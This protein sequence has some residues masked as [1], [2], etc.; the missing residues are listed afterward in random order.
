MNIYIMNTSTLSADPS[1]KEYS[2]STHG[3]HPALSTWNNWTERAV[4]PAWAL[5]LSCQSSYCVLS[6]TLSQPSSLSYRL[7]LPETGTHSSVLTGNAGKK[8]GFLSQH[9]YITAHPWASSWLRL[10][11]KS[12]CANGQRTRHGPSQQAWLNTSLVTV[13]T[14]RLLGPEKNVTF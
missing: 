1:V 12:V 4:I 9:Q 3:P 10:W 11:G 8:E 13:E 5:P 14:V 7:R 2:S 6:P